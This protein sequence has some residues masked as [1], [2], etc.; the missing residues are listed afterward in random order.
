VRASIGVAPA[1]P[2]DDL[3]GLLRNADIAMY[4]AKDSG[5]GSYQRYAPDMAARLAATAEVGTRLREAIGSEQFHL[6]YQP[7]VDLGS[8]AVVGAEALVRWD[9]PGLSP[10]EFIPVAEQ[11]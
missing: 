3:E 8:G 4:A 2:D 9:A 6:V 1:A 5:K 10:A 11:T 7:I